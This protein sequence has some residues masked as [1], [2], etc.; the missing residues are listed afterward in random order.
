[1]MTVKMPP[2]PLTGGC[3]CGAVRYEISA[4]PVMFYLCHCSECQTQTSSA[5][6]ES[7]RCDPA[8]VTVTGKMATT[9]RTAESGTVRFGDF[10]P[11]CGVRIQHRSKGDPGRLNIKA[12]TL[13]DASWLAPAGHIWTRSRQVFV[14]IGEG[15]L[16]YREA[17]EDGGA[18]MQA[19][20]RQMLG[21]DEG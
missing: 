8:F 19:R 10:C 13:D 4:V 18:A 1:M 7:L 11:E 17:P 5:F 21:L 14:T 20:W 16:S 6:G 15:E 2:L 9:T 3:Q 12:G